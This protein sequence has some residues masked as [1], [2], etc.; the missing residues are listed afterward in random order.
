[1]INNMTADV[2]GEANWTKGRVSQII[3]SEFLFGGFAT[4]CSMRVK[5]SFRFHCCYLFGIK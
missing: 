2:K 5:N 3:S 4:F 1:M